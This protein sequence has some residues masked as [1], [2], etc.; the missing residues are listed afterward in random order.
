MICSLNE[1]PQG[2]L[3]FKG[4]RHQV[5]LLLGSKLPNQPHSHMSPTEHGNSG[6]KWKS[7]LQK[8]LFMKV[9]VLLLTPKIMGP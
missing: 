5:D 9:L 7:L 6:V 2:L 4:I 3:P 1:L 8:I